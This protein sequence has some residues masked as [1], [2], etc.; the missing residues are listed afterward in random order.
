MV[1]H[2]CVE[3]QW[4]ELTAA[5]TTVPLNYR[6]PCSVFSRSLKLGSLYPL[7]RFHTPNNDLGVPTTTVTIA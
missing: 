4:I 5:Q 2:E 6:T 3:E 7:R 1:R